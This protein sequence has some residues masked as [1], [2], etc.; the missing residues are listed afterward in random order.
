M[1]TTQVAWLERLLNDKYDFSSRGIYIDDAVWHLPWF[2]YTEEELKPQYLYA[3]SENKTVW[4][5]T[6]GEA[7]AAKDDFIVFVPTSIQMSEEE[8][9]SYLDNY[10]LFGTKYKIERV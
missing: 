3:E 5:Y 6:D 8:M 1:I 9:R 2:L 7:G 10:R 4:L